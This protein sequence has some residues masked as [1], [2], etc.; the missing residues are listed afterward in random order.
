MR[1]VNQRVAVKVIHM[2]TFQHNG[3][4]KRDF[5]PFNLHPGMQ[6]IRKMIR[7]PLNKPG[8][9]R[10]KSQQQVERQEKDNQSCKKPHE[11]SDTFFNNFVHW[12]LS[13]ML[14]NKRSALAG[15]M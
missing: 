13:I 3:A 7:E 15:Q 5:Y 8:L 2:K 10:R 6:H 11:N 4:R 9:Y 1:N 12:L 14:I